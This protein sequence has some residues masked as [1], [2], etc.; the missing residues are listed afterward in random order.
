MRLY[1]T[2]SSLLTALLC[3]LFSYGQD[4]KLVADLDKLLSARFTASTP[5]CAVLVARKGQV[6]YQKAFGSADLELNVPLQPAM[7]FEI[8][9]ITKQFTAVA[10]LQLAEQGKL[11]LQDSIQKY[12]PDFPSKKY[13]I[14]IEH[15]LTHTSGIKDYLQIDDPQPYMERWDF[16]AQQLVDVFKKRPLEFEPGT[17]YKYSNSGYALLGYIIE[18]IS[19]KKYETYLKE[20]VLSPLGMN[21]TYYDNGNTIIPGRASG[22]SRNGNSFKNA[23]FWSPSIAYAAGGLIS[24]VTDLFKWN[25]GLLAYKIINKESLDKAFTAN[26]LKD[27]T[28]TNYGYG[29]KIN[30]TNG[31]RSIEHDGSKNGFVSNELYFP[32]QDV[33][34]VLLFNVENAPKEELAINIAGLVLG[35]SL[36][37]DLALSADILN[38][39]TGTYTLV[40]DPKRKL[41]IEKWKDGL[42]A[43]A[44]NEVLPLVFQSETKFQFK[45][46]LAADCEFIVTGG[47]A[48][49][50]LVNQQGL[51]EWK[52]T[53]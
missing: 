7:V 3:F 39:Y 16:T 20:Q 28:V 21:D 25:R 46:L 53:D 29:W 34:V 19:G 37:K 32:E 42:I 31:I 33:F 12:L 43:R 52:K 45:N 11:S 18:K 2:Y 22:Y 48:T 4:K 49:S 47:K 24:N 30:T 15:L 51:Y 13:T 50:I 6:V 14:T 8:A 40:Q 10:I 5:G 23:D 17:K 41:V 44:S 26:T 1:K 38:R 9:S 35:T 27:G 36:Q